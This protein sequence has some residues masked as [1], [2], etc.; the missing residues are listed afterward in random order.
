MDGG[1]F[2]ARSL[3]DTAPRPETA[4][5][6]AAALP[7]DAGRRRN[8]PDRAFPNRA[9]PDRALSASL[10]E[11]RMWRRYGRLLDRLAVRIARLPRRT[12][13]LATV[14]L[15]VASAG[16]GALA[17]RTGGHVLDFFR[18][19][20]DGAA[21]A[22]GFPI[23]TVAVSGEKH[24]SREEI[25]ALAGVTSHTSLLFYDVVDARARLL[26]NPWIAEAT[27]QKFL[28]DRLVISISERAAFALWQKEGR[29]GVIAADGT[30]LEP[31]VLPR[32]AGLPFVVGAGAET[33]A[34]E[35]LGYLERRPG[36]RAT[37]RAAVLVAERRWNL[38]LKNG[39]DVRLPE[40]EVERALD[41]LIA[42]EHD[43]GL[44]DRDVTAIDLRLKDRVTV[45]LSEN[46]FK[47][48]EAAR[49]LLLQ[50]QKPKGG[51]A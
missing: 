33:R 3:T 44:S 42:L 30:V 32:Y 21:V 5:A 51:S 12:L 7:H 45:A 22:L 35:F 25:V 19:I 37:V 1:G 10:P 43:T 16:Y 49:K 4:A 11:Q 47:A 28:P 13:T 6:N 41:R 36:L 31:E 40:F 34:Q 50:Q 24:L 9:F 46:A 26:T 17:A 23:A 18:D 27:V 2:I 14:V 29:I 20:R 48:R 8:F 38:R 39:V 15:I